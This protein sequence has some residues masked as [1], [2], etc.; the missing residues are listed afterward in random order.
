M[1]PLRV[2]VAKVGLD[3][4]D[5]GATVVARV[6]R[7]AGHEVLFSAIGVTPAMAA[8]AAAHDNVDVVVLTMPNELADRLAGMV[9]HEL[10][11]R[12]VRSRVVAAGIAVKHLEPLLLRVGVSAVVGAAPT[13][14]QIRAA[15]EVPPVVAA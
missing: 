13:V 12:G 4:A 11:R 7:D 6:L 9:V 8:A 3:G 1:Q 2:M 10:E 14:A 15:V 5:R